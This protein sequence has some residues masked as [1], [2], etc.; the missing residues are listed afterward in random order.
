MNI[1]LIGFGKMGQEIAKM[2]PNFNAKIVRVIQNESDW[3]QLSSLTTHIDVAIDFSLPNA[4]HTNIKE[5]SH[6]N[7]PLVIGTTGWY[8]N[9]SVYKQH[10]INNNAKIVW[11]SNFSL[12]LNLM[13]HLTK[14]AATL[15]ANYKQYQPS[16]NEVHHIQKIDAPSGTAIS[17]AN[18]I[19]PSYPELSGWS[20]DN[21]PNSLHI[22]VERTH[23]VKGIHTLLWTSEEDV[24]SI[25]HNALS[26]IGFSKG[27]IS[28][29]QWLLQQKQ[30]WYEIADFL[31][32]NKHGTHD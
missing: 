28:A 23:N 30:G 10:C 25:N 31:N 16:M 8:E 9:M 26:R 1:L 21:L 19:L 17:L 29:A 4:V 2:A 24:I 32:F 6:R 11:A 22:S 14:M 15:L 7:I 18:S 12:G 27:A 13:L 3:N 20:I 5:C